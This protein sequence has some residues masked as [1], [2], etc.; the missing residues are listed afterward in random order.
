MLSKEKCGTCWLFVKVSYRLRRWYALSHSIVKDVNWTGLNT[1]TVNCGNLEKDR[2]KV[3]SEI[4]RAGIVLH[5]QI[6]TKPR[7]E[8]RTGLQSNPMIDA[9]IRIPVLSQTPKSCIF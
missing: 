8:Q 3:A 7:A 1:V 5:N 9:D 4:T 2:Y 6:H